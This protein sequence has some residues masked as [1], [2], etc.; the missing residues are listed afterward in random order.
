MESACENIL[1]AILEEEEEDVDFDDNDDVEMIDVEAGELVEDHDSVNVSSQ[2]TASAECNEIN[3]DEAGKKPES[4]NKKKKRNKKKKKRNKGSGPNGPI[5]I[6]RFVLDTCR[7][8]KEKKNIHGIH[9][10]W[11]PRG[12][13]IKRYHQRAD[14]PSPMHLVLLFLILI[15]IQI[16][17][18]FGGIP[19]GNGSLHRAQLLEL[20]LFS[21]LSYISHL[22]SSWLIFIPEASLLPPILCLSFDV[23]G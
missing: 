13:C 5:N 22:N 20:S 10:Y 19:P 6:D 12:F 15:V 18:V 3:I 11:L 1:E 21:D 17:V 2:T 8:L 16:P 7:R 9:S 14:F 4:N 23:P